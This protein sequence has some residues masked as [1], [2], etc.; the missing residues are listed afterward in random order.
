[1][2][3]CKPLTRGTAKAPGHVPF[4]DC[5]LTHIL[6]PCLG[7]DSKTLMFVHAGMVILPKYHATS[8]V[9]SPNASV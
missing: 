6:S 4:R 5:K 1:V 9:V 2:E 8:L 3:E 7:G